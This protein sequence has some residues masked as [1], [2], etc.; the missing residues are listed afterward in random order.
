MEAVTFQV[1]EKKKQKKT[2]WVNGGAVK[3]IWKMPRSGSLNLEKIATAE[4]K[5]ETSTGNMAEEDHCQ[6]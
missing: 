4:E 5:N 1:V 2:I 6:L 3:F